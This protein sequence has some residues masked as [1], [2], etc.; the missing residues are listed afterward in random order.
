MEPQEPAGGNTT[1][2]FSHT[3]SP[4]WHTGVSDHYRGDTSYE[5]VWDGPHATIRL[6]QHAYRVPQLDPWAVSA[7]GSEHLVYNGYTPL[8]HTS[9]H[10]TPRRCQPCGTAPTGSVLRQ[11]ARRHSWSHVPC[12]PPTDSS[13]LLASPHPMDTSARH[14]PVPLSPIPSRSGV[15]TQSTRSMPGH[16]PNSRIPRDGPPSQAGNPD[17]SI[18]D[19][20]SLTRLGAGGR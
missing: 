14:C 7:E 3:E 20:H 1:P 12:C 10:T 15:A 13:A 19:G 6:V 11:S 4:H 17:Q 9:L 18:R 5:R 2:Q 8:H 16:P